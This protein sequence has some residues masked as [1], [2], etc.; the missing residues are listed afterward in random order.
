MKRTVLLVPFLILG[1]CEVQKTPV[2]TGGS[3]ADAL[4]DMS[5][6]VGGLEV[7]V[8]DWTAAA[9]SAA[10]RCAAWGYRKADAFEGTRTQCH[11]RDMYGNC[12]MATVT[13][14]YQCTN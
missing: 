13:K 3:K 1:A 4:V 12:S 14:T 2:P 7:P 5:Y 8:V 9:A 10:K 6:D 11:S